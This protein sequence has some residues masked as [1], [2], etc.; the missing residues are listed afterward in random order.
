MLFTIVIVLI[1]ALVIIAVI[2]NAA[3]QHKEKQETERRA[4]MAKYKAIIEETEEVLMNS[5]N[6]PISNNLTNVLHKRIHEALKAM[7][8]LSPNAKEVKTRLK[9]SQER[10]DNADPN[11]R[12][13]DDTV[14]M[15]DSDAQI[16]NVVQGIKKLRM[17]LRSEHSKGNVDSQIFASEDRRLESLQLQINVESQIRR[18]V[19]AKN[20][21]MLGSA[22]QYFEKAI[23]TLDGQSYTD[24]FIAGKTAEVNAY[25][26]EITKELK[27]VNAKDAKN[28]EKENEDELDLLFA[29]KKKW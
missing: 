7:L 24:E 20:S 3:Q 25:L 17:V 28:K 10:M 22:R 14:N 8:D 23:A 27:T 26:D 29:P 15:P 9:Q 21:N 6:V 11:V 4:Q 16:I 1:I 2:V 12:S 18:G 5:A 13:N 19:K